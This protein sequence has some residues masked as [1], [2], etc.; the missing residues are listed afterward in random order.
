[1]RQDDIRLNISKYADYHYNMVH[2]YGNWLRQ[3][4]QQFRQKYPTIIYHDRI[5][6]GQFNDAMSDSIGVP[7]LARNDYKEN[8]FM[9]F[10]FVQSILF[11]S[12]PIGFSDFN[13]IDKYLPNELIAISGQ[14]QSLQ[15]IIQWLRIEQHATQVRE[16]LIND[17]ISKLFNIKTFIDKVL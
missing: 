2:F 4:K 7:L 5:G 15:K 1:M 14:R 10:R 11:G 9:T 17:K 3:D 13:H 8:G 12:I 6:I 16:Y